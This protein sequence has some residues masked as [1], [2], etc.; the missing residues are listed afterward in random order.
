MTE[1]KYEDPGQA[2]ILITKIGAGEDSTKYVDMTL[3][4][5]SF[6][7]SFVSLMVTITFCVYLSVVSGIPAHCAD[8]V[9]C[10]GERYCQIYQCHLAVRIWH[11]ADVIPLY[12]FYE[13]FCDAVTFRVRTLVVHSSSPSI[14]LNA[15]VSC[16]L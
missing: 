6:C 10:N 12:R 2:E 8:D 14:R 15:G 4:I 13:A 3:C 7:L 11:N 16:T 5:Q 9:H 1:K